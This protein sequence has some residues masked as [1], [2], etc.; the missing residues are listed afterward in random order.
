MAVTGLEAICDGIM[1]QEG[2]YPGSRSNRNRNPGNLRGSPCT[3]TRDADD[4]DVFEALPQG[5][6]ALMFDVRSKA[7][8]HTEHGL[9]P[10][11]T[12]DDLFDVYAPRSD[13]NNPNAYAVAVAQW[14]TQ[15]LERPCTH[16]STLRA[17][18]V[19]LFAQGGS[20]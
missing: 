15:A 16:N 3:A 18:C 13:K 8:G 7:T 9:T 1:R 6:S 19:E 5:Y 12:L 10:N 4:Y 2:W 17:V 11:S 20:A 14:C